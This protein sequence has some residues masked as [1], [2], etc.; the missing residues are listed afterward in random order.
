MEQLA[1]SVDAADAVLPAWPKAVGAQYVALRAALSRTARAG[2]TDLARQ[3]TGAR[4]ARLAPMLEALAALA[5]A[6]GAGGGRYV[7]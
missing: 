4:P 6:R 5:Q 2:P 3:F 1:L 7:A